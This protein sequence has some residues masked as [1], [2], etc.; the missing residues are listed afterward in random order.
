MT[1]RRVAEVV[2]EADRLGERLVELQGAG[3]AATDLRDLDRVREARAVEIAF[4]VHEHL[5]LVDEAAEGVGVDDAVAVAL[6]RRAGG[7]L[8]LGQAPP[9]RSARA[10]RVRCQPVVESVTRHR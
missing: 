6:E 3:D 7:S 4:V 8:W 9:A 10:R 1:E 5:G 2:R